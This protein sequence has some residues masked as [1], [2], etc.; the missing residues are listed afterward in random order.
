MIQT[1]R[2]K[3]KCIHILSVKLKGG[4]KQKRKTISKQVI[5]KN[6]RKMLK[7]TAQIKNKQ[8]LAEDN[9]TRHDPNNHENKVCQLPGTVKRSIENWMECEKCAF[10]H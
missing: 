2:K 1:N 10:C 4:K 8:N 3:C 7:T 5:G 9:V 6:L